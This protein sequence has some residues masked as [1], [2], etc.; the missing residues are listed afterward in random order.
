MR[1]PLTHEEI[2]ALVAPYALGALPEDEIPAV[3]SHILTCEECTVEAE[4]LSSIASGLTLTV[5]AEEPPAGFADRVFE[6][7][8]QE[9]P[10]VAEPSRWRGRRFLPA[11]GVAALLALTAIFG[12][13]WLDARNDLR[14]RDEVVRALLA[15]DGM[16]LEGTG[17]TGKMVPTDDGAIF[18]ATGLEAPPDGETYQLWVMKGAC[19]EDEKGPCE[20]ES[21]GTF[22]ASGGPVVLE[23]ARSID[24]FDQAAVTVE[25]DGGSNQP[26]TEPVIVSG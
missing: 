20:I 1:K 17:A 24:G 9:A 16:E 7:L 10:S 19:G 18:A 12:G 15:S 5:A 6:R 26:T 8:D 4:E 14:E 21:V 23:T 11:L 2:K 22:D 13:A 3:R 25:P